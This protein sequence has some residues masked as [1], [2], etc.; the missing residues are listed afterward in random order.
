MH[1]L[2][3][4]VYSKAQGCNKPTTMHHH[5]HPHHS[6]QKFILKNH[7]WLITINSFITS[8]RITPVMKES[9]GDII[10]NNLQLPLLHFY[11]YVSVPVWNLFNVLLC[12]ANALF[13]VTVRAV[14]FTV[15][16]MFKTFISQIYQAHIQN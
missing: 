8:F 9:C 2:A 12:L 10:N 3:Q 4:P 7:I 16:Y 6:V 14:I 15:I 13:R 5:H 11:R 1:T